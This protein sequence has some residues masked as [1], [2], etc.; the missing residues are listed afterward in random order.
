MDI[1]YFHFV[2]P[3]SSRRQP[4]TLGNGEHNRISTKIMNYDCLHLLFLS[5]TS[6]DERKVDKATAAGSIQSHCFCFQS[7]Y[8]SFAVSSSILSSSSMRCP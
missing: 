5:A 3:V 4:I 1:G 6:L 2:C 7:K 8:V